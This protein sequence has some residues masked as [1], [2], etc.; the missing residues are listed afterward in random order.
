EQ[1]A[2]TARHRGVLGKVGM[3]IDQPGKNDHIFPIGPLHGNRALPSAQIVV[4]ADLHDPAIGDD[5]AAIP[6]A[7]QRAIIRRVDQ[8]SA[9][10][11]S[12]D[13][14]FHYSREPIRNSPVWEGEA[15][16]KKDS[17]SARRR[18]NKYKN[19]PPPE[20]P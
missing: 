5:D 2:F 6:M 3:T 1:L 11:E 4:G 16:Q 9:D 7:A 10:S 13:L 18:N 20:S 14:R 15:R 19:V 17:G 8:K 12:A